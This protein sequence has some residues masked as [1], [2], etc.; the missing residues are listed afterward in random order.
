[1]TDT[2]NIELGVLEQLA[3]RTLQVKDVFNLCV[4]AYEKSMTLVGGEFVKKTMSDMEEGRDSARLDSN[5]TEVDVAIPTAS[6]VESGQENGG[7]VIC[8]SLLILPAFLV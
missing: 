6:V 4:G 5:S 8:V 1:V 7:V 3:G 2:D